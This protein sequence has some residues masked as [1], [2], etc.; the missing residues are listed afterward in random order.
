VLELGSWYGRSTIAIAS[1][2]RSVDAV[3]PHR[4]GPPGRE[5]TL[6]P[7][8]ANLERYGVRERV[9]VHAGFSGDVVPTLPPEAYDLV[10]IDAD[11]SEPAVREDL[12]LVVPHVRPGGVI[13]FH[14]YGQPGTTHFGQWH[15][16][17]VTEVVDEFAR[18]VGN[19]IRVVGSL[20]LVRVPES[21]T[22]A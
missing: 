15:D 11:H 13:A 22:S 7:F 3:D 8:V 10:F 4:F 21:P 14:D 9:T 16:W 5:D 18:E 19:S 12:R 2:A 1:V 6:A 20:A 17:G